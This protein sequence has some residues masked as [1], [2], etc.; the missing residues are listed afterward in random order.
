LIWWRDL[1]RGN[2][3]NAAESYFG[4]LAEYLTAFG[5][6]PEGEVEHLASVLDI[7]SGESKIARK[8]LAPN[9][10]RK[11]RSLAA[12]DRDLDLA[13][14]VDDF[15]RSGKPLQT[16]A[17]GEGAF[18]LVAREYVERLGSNRASN[19]AGLTGAINEDVVKH[20]WEQFGSHVKEMRK[21]EPQ[22][23][24]KPL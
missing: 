15:K 7:L 3:A 14:R 22:W 2:F 12:M 6:V 24:S 13:F 19:K 10:A 8:L 1:A 16:N 17:K 9:G 20:A 5:S 23:R 4:T 18:A 11:P 21:A